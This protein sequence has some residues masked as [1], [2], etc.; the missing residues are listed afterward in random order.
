MHMLVSI[1]SRLSNLSVPVRFVL[2]R[3]SASVSF[4]TSVPERFVLARL[5][6]SVSC[7]FVPHVHPP[8]FHSASPSRAFCS[9]VLP[10][11][12]FHPGTRFPRGSYLYVRPRMTVPVPRSH[13]T[14]PTCRPLS[15]ILLVCHNRSTTF[16]PG[17]F[18]HTFILGHPEGGGVSSAGR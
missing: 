6:P 5:S 1:A 9:P 8:A 7:V 12:A 2:A 4:S 16:H 14:V 15:F 3:P 11:C 10:S 18:I 13:P 17:A